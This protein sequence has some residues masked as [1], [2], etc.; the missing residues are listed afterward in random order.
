ILG[1]ITPYMVDPTAANMGSK[2]FFVWGSTCTLCALFAFFLVSETKGL[3][4][5]QVDQMLEQTTPRTS[6]KWRPTTTFAETMGMTTSANTTAP[7]GGVL[8]QPKDEAETV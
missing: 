7:S 3:S 4:L 8:Q 6:A 2:V 5:E 1:I